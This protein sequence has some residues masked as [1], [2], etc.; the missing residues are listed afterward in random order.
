[1]ANLVELSNELEFV[2]KEQLIQMSQDPNSTY[3]SY[4]VLSE[5]QRRTQMEKMYAAQQPKPET[6]VSEEV[7]A[8]FAGSPSGLGAMAQSSDTPNAFQSGDMGNMA[9]PSPLMAAA[10]GGKISY[11]EG[12]STSDDI[13]KMLSP[14]YALYSGNSAGI[15]NMVDKNMGIAPLIKSY[16][17]SRK[18]DDNEDI[19]KLSV[20]DESMANGGLT[21]YQA[22]G[23]IGAGTDSLSATFTNPI[24]NQDVNNE[25]G[26]LSK[27]INWA[28]ENPTD[29]LSLAA[30]A[31]FFIPGVGVVLGSAV[32]GGIALL[33]KVVAAAKK[34][35]PAIKSG[36]QKTYTV[37]N[38]ALQGG[39]K[40]GQRK[41]INPKTK[42]SK[43]I[44]T[45]TGKDIP[46]RA[47]SFGR[48]GVAALPIVGST[49]LGIE[50]LLDEE[51]IN[52]ATVQTQTE[53]SQEQV[54]KDVITGDANADKDK[55]LGQ[56]FKDFVKSSRGA[57]MLIGL[58]GAIG[59]AR[60]LGE[61]SSGISDAYF[62]IKSAEQ[63]SELQGLQGR[64]LEAQTAK[65]EADVAN[66]PLDIAIKQ[67]QSLN[68]L[69]DS[70]VLTPDE[71]KVRE[72]AL[73]KRIQQ[74]QGITVAEKDKRDELLGLV[75]EVG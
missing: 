66:M 55:G 6:T 60:N 10:S 2:P 51:E 59:S 11:E 44:D 67:Y 70:G 64:L 5:I 13:L 3:P 32:K 27:A 47:F 56:R 17:D 65:Y 54:F 7:V 45:A 26:F 39:L 31:T 73:L 8:E 16:L 22:G 35:A 48:T 23:S 28:K 74:L 18:K 52:P 46:E 15:L 63:A 24:Q 4:L 20:S 9:P 25:S 42:T 58:G 34:V 68:D 61:L 38:P 19:E 53:G 71:A 50:A 29:A 21:G 12:G 14:A 69:V 62:G 72:A 36:V 49:K 75:Q 1:M 33:P 30:N 41:V 40:V 37:P 43:I 57:D